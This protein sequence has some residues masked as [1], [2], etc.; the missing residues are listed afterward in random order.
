[1]SVSGDGVSLAQ[2]QEYVSTNAVEMNARNVVGHKYV[3]T[4]DT[5]VAVKIAV[6]HRFVHIVANGAAAKN[7]VASSQ[8][9]LEQQVTHL[10]GMHQFE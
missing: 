6:A 2:G 8:I 1:M 10:S 7:V 5:R 3:L 9:Q 4:V